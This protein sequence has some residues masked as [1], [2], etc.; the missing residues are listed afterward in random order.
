MRL[1]ST[2]RTVGNNRTSGSILLYLVRVQKWAKLPRWDIQNDGLSLLEDAGSTGP[3][4]HEGA[5]SACREHFPLK[6][7]PGS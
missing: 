1:V 6:I 2:T 7:D 4:C 3:Q 5:V